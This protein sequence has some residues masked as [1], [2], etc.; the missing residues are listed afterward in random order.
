MKVS[1]S[2][3][4]AA[5]KTQAIAKDLGQKKSYD[6]ELDSFQEE[7]NDLVTDTDPFEKQLYKIMNLSNEPSISGMEL[8]KTNS[9][10][11]K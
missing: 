10:K 6:T 7:I 5:L 2:K 11:Y 1:I 4:N 3:T 8:N 9:S